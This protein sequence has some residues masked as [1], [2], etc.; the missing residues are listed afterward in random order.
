M[1]PTVVGTLC[2]TL[3]GLPDWADG[4]H[5]VTLRHEAPSTGTVGQHSRSLLGRRN[6]GPQAVES[7]RPSYKNPR[8]VDKALMAIRS[9]GNSPVSLPTYDTTSEDP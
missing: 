4:L 1:C 7:G 2:V 5:L 3:S 8:G 9:R 6:K